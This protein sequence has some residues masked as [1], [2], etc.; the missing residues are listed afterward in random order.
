[1]SATR[2]L[3][4]ADCGGINPLMKLTS[5]MTQDRGRRQEGLRQPITANRSARGIAQEEQVGETIV[6]T[7][8]CGL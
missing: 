2:D 7:V 5:H 3:V 8:G 6:A 1:M 4:G